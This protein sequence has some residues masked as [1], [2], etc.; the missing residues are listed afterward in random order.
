MDDRIRDAMLRTELVRSPRSRLSTFGS[1][2]VDYYVVTELAESMSAVRDGKVFA[3][4]PK[5]VTP[6]YLLHLDGFGEGSR[7][8]LEMMS[9]EHGSQPGIFYS[10]RNEPSSM[11]VVSEPVAVVLGNMNERLDV[12]N[13]PMSAIIKGV[14]DVWDLAVMM[15]VYDLTRRAVGGH[16]ADFQRRGLLDIDSSGVPT[17]ARQQI[18][19][20]FGIVRDDRSRASDLVTE[21][22]RWGVYEQ[23]EDRFLSLFKQ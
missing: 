8:Y 10:Y 20:L 5:I 17:A 9:Q 3:E 21:L 13:A 15:F 19:S 6:Y 22:K 23:Y 18:E 1:T 14:E 11:N 4:R 7:R 12:E 2:T 16:V